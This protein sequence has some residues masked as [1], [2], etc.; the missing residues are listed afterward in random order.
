MSKTV[1]LGA[2][3]AYGI[4]RKYGYT[5]TEEEWNALQNRLKNEAATYANSARSSASAALTSEQN[6]ATSE[7]NAKAYM[8]SAE[9]SKNAAFS[10]TPEGYEANVQK[11]ED[12]DIQT[13][14]GESLNLVGTRAGG[15]KLNKITG[16]STQNQY[17]GKNLFKSELKTTTQ[18]GVTCTKN[19]DDT[20]TLN[21]TATDSVE[22]LLYREITEKWNNKKLRIVGCPSGG[23][24]SKY[25]IVVS[26]IT[27]A[28]IEEYGLGNNF[29]PNG[30][31]L[32][33]IIQI[34]VNTTL[35]KLIF[36]PMLVDASTYPDA[37]YDDYEPYVG[38]IPAPNPDYP[39]EIK[40]AGD[41]G[42][43][44]VTSC[45]KNLYDSLTYSIPYSNKGI[46][47][48]VNDDGTI[49]LTG[50]P[51][52][53][54]AIVMSSFTL[55]IGTYTFSADGVK[56]TK[57]T[58]YDKENDK[59]AGYVTSTTK[60][61]TFDVTDSTNKYALDV[62][63]LNAIELN[64]TLKPQ[65]EKGSAAT[66]YEPY[67]STEITI[68]L[69][70]PLRSIGDVK[71]EI[72]KQDGKWG[73]LRR[74]TKKSITQHSAWKT[75]GGT[76][77]T[78]FYLGNFFE[79][80]VA[81]SDYDTVADIISEHFTVVTPYAIC[82]TDD[83]TCQG[84]HIAQGHDYHIYISI[85]GITS[86]NE[87]NTWLNEHNPYVIYELATPVFEP[88]TDQTPFYGLS[89]FDGVTNIITD[90]TIEPTLDIEYGKS[91]VGAYTLENHNLSKKNEAVLTDLQTAYLT[92]LAQ[93]V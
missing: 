6:A 14:T 80:G 55:P 2:C 38:A 85:N 5:G 47:E 7:A 67:Q 61:I 54:V 59:I 70:E 23:S 30:T 91:Q 46:T 34:A 53:D 15:I 88:F 86:I 4:A 58:I 17:L 75:N 49:K 90:Q 12:M 82:K 87:L 92:T 18:N 76:D 26:D 19:E 52:R 43:V 89:S 77:C 41:D 62:L 36:K 22:F 50:T 84:K 45:G 48:I 56:N 68:P 39:Q 60:S 78:T 25:K 13:A 57:I 63:C 8:D 37:T 10:T 65:I 42:S 44:K 32:K 74:I 20:Y 3:T 69:T 27:T 40:S 16:K 33:V 31:G 9:E 79:G 1:N 72:V 64:E 81:I 35:S 29:T 93:E 28:S 73:I 21:G 71:D 66:D 24:N 11:L 51:T 83:N